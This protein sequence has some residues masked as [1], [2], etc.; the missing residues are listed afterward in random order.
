MWPRTH[1]ERSRNRNT[2]FVCFMHRADAEEAMDEYCD[3]DPLGT[4]R[5]MMI[6]W[7]KNVKR[8]V[9]RGTGGVPMN[10]RKKAREVEDNSSNAHAN[11]SKGVVLEMK[12][13][14]IDPAVE[15]SVPQSESSNQEYNKECNNSTVSPTEPPPSNQVASSRRKKTVQPPA[16]PKYDPVQHLAEAIV[17]NTPSDSRRMQFISTVA[18]FVAKDGSIFEQKLIETQNNSD[19]RFLTPCDDDEASD[20]NTWIEEHIFYRWRVYAFTQGDGFNSWRTEPFVMFHPYGRFWCPPPLNTAAALKEEEAE[21]QRENNRLAAQEERRN[22][23]VNKEDCITTGASMRR[24]N[25]SARLNEWERELWNTLLREKLCASQQCICEA[26][27]FAFDKSGA[28]KEISA[29]L[30][31]ALLECD[32]TVDTRI[33]RLFLFSDIL[34]NS[35]QPGVRNAFQCKYGAFIV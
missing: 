3:A 10:F 18:S 12:D 22:M 30:K 14:L 11:Q 15:F 28:A 25:E 26:M 34:F 35:Q 4:G 7:G 1:E 6:R 32:S 5:R 17:V 20:N 19:F 31:E 27:A 33:A 21:K 9:K 23:A 16:G 29:L 24:T 8:S 13:P 2:G